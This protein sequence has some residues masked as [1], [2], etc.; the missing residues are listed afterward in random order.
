MSKSRQLDALIF[1]MGNVLIDW[2]P[3][4]LVRYFGADET[5]VRHIAHVLFHSDAWKKLDLGIIGEDEVIEGVCA[6]LSKDLHPLVNTLVKRWPEANVIDDRMEKLARRL[7]K[8]G[9]RLYL[10]SNASLRF[11]T[12][13]HTI[14]AL[15]YFD[16]IQIS[17]DIKLSKPNPAFYETLV[18]SY[19]L[20]PH[21]TGF[22]DDLAVNCASA[23][24]LGMKSH[25][26]TGDFVAL[27]DWLVAQGALASE[28]TVE[29]ILQVE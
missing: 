28:T 25:H 21:R 19:G 20:S 9:I 14:G 26:Y 12:Y 4:R 13:K 8:N 18:E 1:D 11:H 3:E 27:V 17:A 15:A 6:N 22:I 29:E 7:Q 10:G 23:T 24:A 5:Q 2:T 16:G